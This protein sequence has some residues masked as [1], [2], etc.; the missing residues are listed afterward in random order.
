LKNNFVSQLLAATISVGLDGAIEDYSKS[1]IALSR[2]VIVE[3]D[4]AGLIVSQ[5]LEEANKLLSGAD[6]DYSISQIH[7]TLTLINESYVDGTSD[8]GF[9]TTKG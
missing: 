3:G 8:S 1:D 4:L 7:N 2:A 9:L 6:A 5:V